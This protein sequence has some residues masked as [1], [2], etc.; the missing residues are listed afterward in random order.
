MFNGK[1]HYFYGD[2]QSLCNKLPE[3]NTTMIGI[4]A[5][6]ACIWL[7]VIVLYCTMHN[8]KCHLNTCDGQNL[9]PPFNHPCCLRYFFQAPIVKHILLD[10]VKSGRAERKIAAS[11]LRSLRR[12]KLANV[13]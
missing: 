3:G 10:W 1:T 13:D 2:F 6:N 8:K 12:S 11:M 4:V 7:Q 5:Y 9:Q